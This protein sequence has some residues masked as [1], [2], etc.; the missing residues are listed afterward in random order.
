M[1]IIINI[2]DIIII[3]IIINDYLFIMNLIYNDQ[4]AI[5]FYINPIH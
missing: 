3:I 1:L 2:I 5:C 4:S